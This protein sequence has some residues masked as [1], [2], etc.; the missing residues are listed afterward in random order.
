MGSS[1]KKAVFA[2]IVSDGLKKWH[3][4][5]KRNLVKTKCNS[6][7]ASSE[8]SLSLAMSDTQEL[9]MARREDGLETEVLSQNHNFV[10]AEI[11]GEDAANPNTNTNETNLTREFCFR[12]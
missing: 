4:M 1:M 11:T 8:P 3:T 6:I 9:E 12:P 2:E 7:G 10:I 5:A